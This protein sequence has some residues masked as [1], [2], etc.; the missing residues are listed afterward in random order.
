MGNAK[1]EIKIGGLHFSCEAEQQWVTTQLDKIIAKA[2][3]L[4]KLG[5]KQETDAKAA[6][7]SKQTGQVS[8]LANFLTT[9]NSTTVQVKKFLATA[10]W[11]HLK[12]KEK[13]T[14][15]DVAKSLKDNHQGKLNNPAD[16]LNQNVSKGFCEKD[17]NEFFVTDEGLN[18]LGIKRS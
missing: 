17:G 11:L 6:G 5:E 3:V 15:G 4:G 16:C 12:G 2:D 18:E 8:S 14:T 1:I 7:A 9:K 13:V 10:V